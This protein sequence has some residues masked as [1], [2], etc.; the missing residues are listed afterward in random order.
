[1]YI[2]RAVGEEVSFP[3]V[4]KELLPGNQLV[5]VEEDRKVKQVQG[6]RVG[7]CHPQAERDWSLPKGNGSAGAAEGP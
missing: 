4:G 3:D 7:K 5:L 6:P 1:M 2:A